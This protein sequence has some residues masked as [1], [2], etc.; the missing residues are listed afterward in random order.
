MET[1]MFFS[2]LDWANEKQL[3]WTAVVN[4]VLEQDGASVGVTVRVSLFFMWSTYKKTI[5]FKTQTLW[6]FS[7][8]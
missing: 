5:D 6:M 1:Q 2:H 3:T 8:H 4:R 7:S